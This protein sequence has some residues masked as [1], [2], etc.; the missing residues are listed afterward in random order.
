MQYRNRFQGVPLYT[1]IA[2]AL[3]AQLDSGRWQIGD[4]LEAIDQ[5]S[6][7]F[8]VAVSTMR[9]AIGTLEGEGLL[10]RIHGR[11]T[12][13]TGTPRELRWLPLPTDW[14]SFLR[15]CG[16]LTPSLI[17][18]E[19]S[20]QQ[21]HLAPQEGT[22]APAYHYMRRMHKR[23]DEPFSVIDIYLDSRI[24]LKSPRRFRNE[25]V[26]PLLAELPDVEI[27]SVRGTLLVDGADQ[28]SASLLEIGL[29]S[30][31]ARVRRIICD[32]TGTTIFL[33]EIVYRGDVVRVDFDLTPK[34]QHEQEDRP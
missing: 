30:P 28:E 24:Y 16:D 25:L 14:D 34:Q 8:N 5:L 22:P 2:S 15:M 26:V 21:P 4:Q 7:E 33:A 20:E 31:V 13:V 29:G 9:Q 19:P 23:N 32:E 6:K 11:G 3:R 27:A 10:A 1:Q 12:F 18:A 17:V